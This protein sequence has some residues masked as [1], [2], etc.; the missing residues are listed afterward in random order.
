MLEDKC[1]VER[2]SKEGNRE[3]GGRGNNLKCSGLIR[4]HEDGDIWANIWRWWGNEICRDLGKV[5]L[6][7]WTLNAK[8][9]KGM[10]ALCVQGRARRPVEHKEYRGDSER[11]CEV[12][13]WWEPDCR[14]LRPLQRLW[15][16]LWRAVGR[17]M[18]LSE[19]HPNSTTTASAVEID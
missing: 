16:L 1:Y 11:K 6:V 4:A 18:T 7:E 2:Q 14:I 3:C 12:R 17:R 19:W 8:A 9:L 5:L 10:H 15:L 13:K